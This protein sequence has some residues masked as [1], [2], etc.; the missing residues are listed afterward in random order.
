MAVETSPS[1]YYAVLQVRPDADPEVIEAV[2]RR[3]M[4]M[5][6]PDL[7]GD[8]SRRVA[9]HTERAAAINQAFSILRDPEKR[10]LYDSTRGVSG[11]RPPSNPARSAAASGPSASVSPNVPSSTAPQQPPARVDFDNWMTN[12]VLQAPFALLSA[13][14]YLLPGPYEWEA[15]RGRELRAVFL[16]PPLGVAGFAMATGRLAPWIGQS[17]K[18]TVVAWLILALLSLPAWSSLPRLAVAGVPTL[19]LLSGQM[20]ALIRQAHMP[21][22]VVGCLLC[23]LGLV[24]SARLYVFA[25]LPT[26][27]ICWLISSFG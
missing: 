1:N 5:Y 15:H 26:V 16:V 4:K 17:L 21:G 14:Y 23:V 20:D 8:D 19:V 6:H 10:R 25:I 27:A 22:W 3:L 24:L 11:T 7:A 2:Y 9:M 12:S 18:V 13:A